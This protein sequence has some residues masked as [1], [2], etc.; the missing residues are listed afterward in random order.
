VAGISGNTTYAAKVQR[1]AG[2]ASAAAIKFDYNIPSKELLPLLGRTI[3]LSFDALKGANFSGANLSC[4]INF[5]TG[6][7]DRGLTGGATWSAGSSSTTITPALTAGRFF[8]GNINVPANATKACV[9]FSYTPSGT[10]GADDSFTLGRFRGEMGTS[11]TYPKDRNPLDELRRC[12]AYF[13]SYDV[14]KG[15]FTA[16]VPAFYSYGGASQVVAHY[17]SLSILMDKTPVITKIGTWTVSNCAQPTLAASP[18]YASF[19]TTAT[20][21]GPVYFTGSISNCGYSLDA[22]ITA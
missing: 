9:S 17:P 4:L 10:A 7:V 11:A 12:M 2:D 6:T 22:R 13:Q 14:S 18:Q 16:P 5:G 20:A 21:A 3:S 19:A 1:T 8:L 15:N